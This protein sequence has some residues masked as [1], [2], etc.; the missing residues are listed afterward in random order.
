MLEADSCPPIPSYIC[1]ELLVFILE[2]TVQ[3]MDLTAAL[4]WEGQRLVSPFDWRE[5]QRS[6]SFS[7]AGA[8]S[9]LSL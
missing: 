6:F 3:S 8:V 5:T 2:G 7:R 4:V 1:N 9:F